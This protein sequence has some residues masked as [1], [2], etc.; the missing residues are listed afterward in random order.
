[1]VPAVLEL[2]VDGTRQPVLSGKASV[3]DVTSERVPVLLSMNPTFRCP[4]EGCLECIGC[5]E[6]DM[7]FREESGVIA[8]AAGLCGVASPFLSPLILCD[9]ERLG[10][11]KSRLHRWGCTPCHASDWEAQISGSLIVRDFGVVRW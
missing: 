7:D 10:E 3:T 1:M 5:S 6:P 9:L 8:L 4:V 2:P 11:A